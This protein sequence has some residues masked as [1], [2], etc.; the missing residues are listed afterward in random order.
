MRIEFYSRL[1]LMVVAT[2]LIIATQVWPALTLEWMF[3]VGGVVMLVLAAADGGE[4]NRRRQALDGAI[5]L[6]GVWSVVQAVVF[7]GDT[8]IWVSFGTALGAFLLAIGGLIEHE[9]ST[10][11]VVHELQVTPASARP[12]AL[13]S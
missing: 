5:A 12:G 3:I 2:F 11:R 13:A 9:T 4:G 10:E 1:A 6:V 7:T 8:L